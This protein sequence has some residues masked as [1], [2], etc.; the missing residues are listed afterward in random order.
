MRTQRAT[1]DILGIPVDDVTIGDALSLFEQFFE[2]DRMAWI[3][4]PNAEIVL[5]ASEKVSLAQTI[6]Q[7]DLIIP[8]GIG[9]LY[10]SNL[11]GRPLRERVAG[12]DFAY[13]ALARCAD[14][15]RSAYFLGGKPGVAEL[16]A[17]RI[18]QD[19]PHLNVAGHHHGYYEPHEESAIIEDINASGAEFLCV[20]LGF[21]RQEQF[22]SI[23]RDRL[24]TK[25]GIGVGGSFDVWSG[26]LS[27][28]P[29]AFQ[30]L[31]LE[32]L[33]RLVQQ[34]KRIGRMARL[35]MFLWKVV[36][37]KRAMSL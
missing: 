34:P 12:I 15:G 22:L 27:R 9:L 6:R 2:G 18:Q 14:A 24:Q 8:D 7:A 5:Q 21:P 11:L 4:T 30:K 35:P 20:A 16:A 19:M 37:Q 33:Y 1:I 26:T 25:A 29:E 31:G 36:A 13:A 10:A 17:V 32:W 28:A 23:Y 3:A